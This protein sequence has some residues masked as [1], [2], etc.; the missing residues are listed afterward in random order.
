[1]KHRFRQTDNFREDILIDE[2]ANFSW[3]I[4]TKL[5]LKS[6]EDRQIS[7]WMFYVPIFDVLGEN[8]KWKVD[9]LNLL[10]F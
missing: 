1:M 8:I 5:S 10:S 3:G 9:I 6:E 2:I 4:H 7:K